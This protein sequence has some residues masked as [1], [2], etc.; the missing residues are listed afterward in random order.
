MPNC[1]MCDGTGHVN[2]GPEDDKPCLCVI[3]EQ[4]EE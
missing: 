1:D 4:I 2:V 3:E